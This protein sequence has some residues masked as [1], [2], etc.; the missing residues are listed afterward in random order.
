MTRFRDIYQGS[1]A[2]Q[3]AFGFSQAGF[4][5][6]R[7]QESLMTFGGDLA[8]AMNTTN[9]VQRPSSADHVDESVAFILGWR[10]ARKSPLGE[11]GL[12]EVAEPDAQGER[13]IGFDRAAQESVESMSRLY[14]IP[15]FGE[16]DRFRHL[17]DGPRLRGEALRKEPEFVISDPVD[18][19]NQ[20]AG[21]SNRS[22]WA[23]CAL[24]KVAGD[25]LAAVAIY[26]GD[27]RCYS[28]YG[29]VVWLSANNHPDGSPTLYRLPDHPDPRGFTRKHY[30]MPASKAS[31]LK[32]A[33]R[34]VGRAEI[35]YIAPLAGNPGLAIG[36]ISGGAM[37]GMQP[38]AYAW[39]HMASFVLASANFTVLTQNNDQPLTSADI[40]ETL[41][42]DLIAGRKTEAMYIG[43]TYEDAQLLKHADSEATSILGGDLR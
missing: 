24:V 20:I 23:S 16:E 31:T 10:E 17:P 1:R 14:R 29:D 32:R 19:S 41:V 27:G 22:G 2:E 37:G 43:R 11:L 3:L 28:A 33:S 13:Q 6:V 8:E 39:D 30:I 18:G 25:P 42:A 5:A 15:L 7:T 36:L 34:V 40:L 35:E 26:V 4:S 12:D 9:T 21:M 38:A